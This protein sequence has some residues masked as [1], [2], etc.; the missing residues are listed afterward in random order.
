MSFIILLFQL[1]STA[2]AVHTLVMRMFL[3][4]ILFY[5]FHF[6]ADKTIYITRYG[7]T[8]CQGMHITLPM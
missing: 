6:Y 7:T 1:F 4:P 2:N 8:K 5:F 3:S